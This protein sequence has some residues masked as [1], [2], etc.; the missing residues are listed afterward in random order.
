MKLTTNLLSISIFL[1]LG[2]EAAYGQEAPQLGQEERNSRGLKIAQTGQAE[3]AGE[4][5]RVGGRQ[6]QLL[7]SLDKIAV[8]Y[9]P[10]EGFS[11][12]NQLQSFIQPGRELLIDREVFEYDITV[13]R[14]S[15]FESLD[16]LGASLR[17]FEQAPGIVRATPVY[18]HEES[19]LEL[20]P[21]DELIVKLAQGVSLDEL[22]GFSEG[23]GAIV[24]RPLGGSTDQFILS[25][26][27][28]TPEEL[29]STC[30]I[31][32]QDPAIE[33]AQ[34]NFLAQVDKCDFRP[35][36]PRYSDQWHLPK[37]QAPQ[38]WDATAGS[39][40]I[41]IA[42]IDDGMDLTHE[43]LQSNLWNNSL[44]IA[45]NGVDD[46]NNGYVDDR[47]G[48]DFFDY[49]PDPNPSQPE[50]NHGTS[51]AGVAAAEGNNNRGVAGGAF[52][53]TLMPLKILKGPGSVTVARSA[54]SIYYA[55]GRTKN[56]GSWRGADVISRS[57]GSSE[58]DPVN[59]ALAFAAAQGRGG[60]GCPIF[61][62]TGNS[63]SNYVPVVFGTEGCPAA[64]FHIDFIYYKD[65]AG[66]SG[67]DAVWIAD[68]TLPDSGGTN[69]RFD[70]PSMPSGWSGAGD[71]GFSII[72]D[73]SHAHGT[74]RYVAR[75]GRIGNNQNSILRTK[76]FQ[77]VPGKMLIFRVWIS[78]EK[79]DD[80][81]SDY[82]PSGNDGD[83]LFVRFVTDGGSAR[84]QVNAGTPGD[85]WP[86]GNFNADSD[87]LVATGISYPA[88][89]P[90]T[91]AVGAS[92]NFDY[93]SHYSQFGTGL[94]FVAPSNGGTQGITT[95]D[96]TGI[97]GYDLGNYTST[98]G[99]TSS[100]TPLAAGVAALMLSINPNLTAQQVREIMRNTCDRAGSSSSD[101]NQYYGYGRINAK[102]A[103]D[104]AARTGSLKVTITPQ[105]AASA[106]AR[107]RRVNTSTWRASGYTEMGI[108]VGMYEV[109]FNSVSGWTKPDDMKV[110]INKSPVTSITAEYT[111]E[112]A[113]LA[114]T[115][116]SGLSASG[117]QGGPFSPSSQ[118]YTL[119]NAGG[120]SLSWTA[121]KSK[122]WVSLSQSS[123]VLAPG[124]STDVT[125]S[126]DSNAN[127]LPVGTHTDTVHFTNQTN[128]I[129]NTS[130]SVT[131]QVT[132]SPVGPSA[133]V[134]TPI[135]EQS[136]TVGRLFTY[137]VEATGSPAPTFSLITKP[138]GMTIDSSTGLIQWTPD[139]S[140]VRAFYVQV[141]ARNSE[142]FDAGLFS[143]TVSQ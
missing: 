117:N 134:I 97:A 104:E 36:D 45:N 41:V 71:L 32:W 79:G 109:E 135:P 80:S 64:S 34:P 61:C 20:I 40:Q 7:R 91:I 70:S 87:E 82:P 101:W 53:C 140:Q 106:G 96:R 92:T 112:P 127:N 126:I 59:N 143:L 105:G 25:I 111:G 107:W 65:A 52:N 133:P 63:A 76:S 69:E 39:S 88:S 54:E 4:F 121:S 66:V 110:I 103:V 27:D 58:F 16:E 22:E 84:G 15:K 83:W 13:L 108:Q 68:V 19:G 62:A 35:N 29:L 3:Y 114:V 94:D 33:W 9:P 141:L 75:S 14:G 56:G 18:I 37:I 26:P 129:G 47:N 93:R 21:T 42:V 136:A 99:G 31:Y 24:V 48:W 137:D 5:F 74:S 57:L 43:D 17:R 138:A 2:F 60:K 6:V 128:G 89:H 55:A 95:T 46:D 50:D 125:V 10:G 116:P 67:E 132:S 120:V 30:E 90:D 72:N 100:S 73:P 8:R 28:C 51:C 123:G 78:T 102:K 81:T 44:E 119:T 11:V 131:L 85:H 49:D 23:I 38:A 115:T 1:I 124:R 12:M 142:G 98:F 86:L 130:R 139:A 118:S 122:S 113:S 77:L